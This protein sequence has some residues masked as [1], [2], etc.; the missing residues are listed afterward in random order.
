LNGQEG[1][2]LLRGGDGLDILQGGDGADSLYGDAGNDTMNGGLGADLL[3]G[4][5]GADQIYTAEGDTV[6]GGAGGDEIIVLDATGNGAASVTDYVA[7][8]DSYVVMYDV[9]TDT[10]PPP[11]GTFSVTASGSD[12]IILR[13]GEAYLRLVGVA[14]A[15]VNLGDFSVSTRVI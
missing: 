9:A 15:A 2:D 5:D 13:N 6:T 7:G 8:Q 11:A 12:S 1:D 10:T 3:V 14:P 4:G